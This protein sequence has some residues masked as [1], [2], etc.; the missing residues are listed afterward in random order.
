MK[1]ET[2][3]NIIAR[4]HENDEITKMLQRKFMHVLLVLKPRLQIGKIL[5]YF[6]NKSKTSKV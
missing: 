6:W 3:T 4:D 5:K 1:N 2:L